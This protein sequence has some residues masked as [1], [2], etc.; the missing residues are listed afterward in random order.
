MLMSSDSFFDADQDGEVTD[1]LLQCIVT[2]SEAG[3]RLDRYVTGKVA[4]LSRSYA[5]QLIT[6]GHIVVNGVD[7]R[8]STVLKVNDV[9]IVRRPLTQPTDL[10][11][12]DIPLEIVYEDANVV[13]VNKSAGMVVH[14]APGHLSGTLVNAL[15]SRYPDIR[16][17]HDL[18]PGIV[19]RLDRETSGLM[20]VARNDA[21]RHWL[22]AQQKAHSMTKLYL[23]LTEGR[24]KEY[25][26][27]IDAPIGRHQ[28]DRRRMII[29]PDGRSAR[30]H[31]RVLEEL[32]AYT[33][34]AAR[35]ETGRTHQIRVHFAYKS[36]PLLGDPIYGPKK[37]R[38]TF[39]LKRQFLHAHR[40]GFELPKTGEWV[41]F[42][43][44]LPTDLQE[45]LE[46]VRVHVGL[47]KDSP[48]QPMSDPFARDPQ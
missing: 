48:E 32:G 43:S 25:E 45:A 22:Q 3:I 40:L 23:A 47:S 15:L 2:A 10:V 21:A 35:L 8:P 46:K 17:G 36:R 6:D 42:T 9:V 29:R 1:R 19:H 31:W 44:P 34:I 18:R 41:E 28:T 16:V 39:G 14:P 33:L 4:D 30:T 11:A 38:T 12:E 24:F 7:V 5:Q 27:L 26:G 13:V 20:V 37:P